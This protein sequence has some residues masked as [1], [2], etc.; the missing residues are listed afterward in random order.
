M[1]VP[2]PGFGVRP[3]SAPFYDWDEYGKGA[4]RVVS[5]AVE[6]DLDCLLDLDELWPEGRHRCGPQN[7][8]FAS[9]RVCDRGEPHLA[10][11]VAERVDADPDLGKLFVLVEDEP[12]FV[13]EGL[14]ELAVDVPFGLVLRDPENLGLEFALLL[15]RVQPFDLAQFH[16]ALPGRE[17]PEVAAGAGG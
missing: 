9:V 12:G 5:D 6:E 16:D 13:P 14:E 7:D 8:L 15:L 11:A 10:A 2:L 1:S 4:S 17:V 3:K